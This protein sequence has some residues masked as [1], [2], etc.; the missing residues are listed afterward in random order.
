MRP[1]AIAS[2]GTITPD[3][4]CTATTA[5]AQI[6]TLNGNLLHISHVR[7]NSVTFTK[8]VAAN[9][10]VSSYFP[11]GATFVG[12]IFAG[13]IPHSTWTDAIVSG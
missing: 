12:V 9:I 5:G 13:A 3:T 7:I 6:S 2:G 4:N 10:D 8:Y 1:V 11:S